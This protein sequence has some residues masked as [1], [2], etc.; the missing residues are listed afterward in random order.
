MVGTGQEHPMTVALLTV[1]QQ[2][3]HFTAALLAA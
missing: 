1:F 2:A 3:E